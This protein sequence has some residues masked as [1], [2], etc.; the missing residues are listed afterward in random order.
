M[1]GYAYLRD[2]EE[3]IAGFHGSAYEANI[4]IWSALPWPGDM[5]L[6]DAPVHASSHEG[7][8][9]AWQCKRAYSDLSAF[10]EALISIMETQPLVNRSKRIILM[11]IGSF[12][13]MDGDVCPL[14]E[15]LHIA[16]ELSGEEK[17]MGSSQFVVD[18]THSI[19]VIGPKGAELVCEL[20]LKREIAVVVHSYGKTMGSTGGEFSASLR[21]FPDRLTPF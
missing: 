15:L 3:G 20:G 18:E 2:L 14:Q 16:H 21:L 13:S 7:I 1:D 6:Y 8:S 9:R 12:Y 11:A 19:G 17:E 10:R 4:A 5:I